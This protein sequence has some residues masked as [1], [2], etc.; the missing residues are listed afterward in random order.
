VLSRAEQCLLAWVFWGGTGHTL[1]CY[2]SEG[3]SSSVSDVDRYVI[4]RKLLNWNILYF[5][6][7]V[8]EG[9]SLSKVAYIWLDQVR[10]VD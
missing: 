1:V 3:A 10:K 6:I 9:N 4:L 8:P 2:G 5:C 7:L